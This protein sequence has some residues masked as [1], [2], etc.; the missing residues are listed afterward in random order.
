MSDNK[1]LMDTDVFTEIV[2][3]IGNSASECILSDSVLNDIEVWE[4]TAVGKKMEKLLRDVLD[5]SKVYKE[6][7][8]VALPVAFLKLRDSM[9]NIDNEAS[10]SIDVKGK[11]GE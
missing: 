9:I 4:N 5:S 10:K 3:S 8:S 11:N 1:V 2:D 6:E 7:A